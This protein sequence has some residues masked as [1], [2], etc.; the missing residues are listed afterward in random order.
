MSGERGWNYPQ[1]VDNSLFPCTYLCLFYWL[2]VHSDINTVFFPVWKGIEG[3]YIFC[4]YRLEYFPFLWLHRIFAGFCTMRLG[5]KK[6]SLSPVVYRVSMFCC[7]LVQ[8]N[9]ELYPRTRI[10]TSTLFGVYYYTITNNIL[11]FMF[12]CANFHA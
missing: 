8:G 10:Q 11:C 3:F 6:V 12:P 7:Y 4:C 9:T 1:S 5:V 2:L